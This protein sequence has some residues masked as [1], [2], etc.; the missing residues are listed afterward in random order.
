MYGPLPSC[1]TRPHDVCL[2]ENWN[3]TLLSVPGSWQCSAVGVF[4][5]RNNKRTAALH[6]YQ[7]IIWLTSYLHSSF[8][9]K[10][11]R[12]TATNSSC[13]LSPDAIQMAPSSLTCK[14]PSQQVF[15][16]GAGSLLRNPRVYSLF[17]LHGPASLSVFRSRATFT[18]SSAH[19][20]LLSHSSERCTN[21]S[22]DR[23][24][25]VEFW[26]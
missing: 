13:H 11:F 23:Y 20:V 16:V 21:S 7:S 26:P 3:V 14:K 24:T 6:T 17:C 2:T 15:C 19:T 4:E 12:T 8:V 22:T 18:V 1:P 25:E 9:S 10:D 5:S